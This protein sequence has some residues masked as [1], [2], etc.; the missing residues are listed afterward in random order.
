[1]SGRDNH[2]PIEDHHNNG[3]FA[4]LGPL[5]DSSQ[6]PELVAQGVDPK[7]PMPS[8]QPQEIELD[9]KREED[10][11]RN[12]FFHSNIRPVDFSANYTDQETEQLIIIF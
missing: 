9:K 5:F 3:G 1:M 7:V 10:Q 8:Y 4:T 11:Y 12:R 6:Q 2:F